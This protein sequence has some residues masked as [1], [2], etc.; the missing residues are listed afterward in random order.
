[1]D[2]GVILWVFRIAGNLQ[3]REE[4]GMDRGDLQRWEE[5]D[6]LQNCVGALKLIIGVGKVW[7]KESRKIPVFY[8][9]GWWLHSLVYGNTEGAAIV[10]EE[11]QLSVRCPLATDFCIWSSKQEIWAGME[12]SKALA[13]R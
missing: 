4:G 12:I 13:S 10:G 6:R 5:G 7:G 2:G 3:E 11:S 1:M 9:N 8:L